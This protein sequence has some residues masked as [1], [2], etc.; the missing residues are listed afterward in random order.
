MPDDNNVFGF[1][2]NVIRF[3]GCGKDGHG[4]D[5]SVKGR[6]EDVRHTRIEFQEGAA[7]VTGCEYLVLDG[8]N[9]GS[10]HGNQVGSW[11]DFQSQFSSVFFGKLAEGIGDG[12]SNFLQIGRDFALDTSDLVS[13]TKVQRFH[14]V[15]DLAKRQGLGGNLLPNGRVTSRSNVCV[16]SF[17][18]KAVF[19][20][21]IRDGSVFDQTEPNSKGRSGSTDIGFGKSRSRRRKTT[22]T[23][24]GVDTDTHLLAGSFESLSDAF[25]LGDGT[26]NK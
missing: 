14:G 16:D 15:P 17:D 24:S 12:F 6:T 1:R 23:G 21:N 25:D 4:V 13:A 19:G 2:S 9:Q 5:G 7:I 8:G 11:L 20:N 22:R 10:A 3:S 18:G 26:V